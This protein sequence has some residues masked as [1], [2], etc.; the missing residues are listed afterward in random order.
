VEFLPVA[1]PQTASELA[2]MISLLEA[3]EICY[4][5]LNRGFGSLYPG[6]SMHLFNDQRIMVVA[7]QAHEAFV[8]LGILQTPAED[9]SA[10]QE[11]LGWGDKLR[12]AAELL[13]GHWC[14]PMRRRSFDNG[15][16]IKEENPNGEL[17]HHP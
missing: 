11:P 4:F 14:F 10:W 5:V 12:V 13:L 8:L 6:M 9:A 17:L 7:P 2:V 1:H 15:P 3:H 16:V